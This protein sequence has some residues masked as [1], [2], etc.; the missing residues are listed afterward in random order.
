MC[1]NNPT[2]VIVMSSISLTLT[3]ISAMWFW[4]R[5]IIDG[6]LGIGVELQ[7]AIYISY[8]FS[9][10]SQTLSITVPIKNNKCLLVPFMICLVLHIVGCI[11]VGIF[12]GGLIGQYDLAELTSPLVPRIFILLSVVNGINIYSLTVDH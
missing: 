7:A 10:T 8:V 5:G 1:C 9:I 3:G 6:H 11:G 4:V 12:F 2:H